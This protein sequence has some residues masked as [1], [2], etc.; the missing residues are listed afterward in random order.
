MI[1]ADNR[2]HANIQYIR[3]NNTSKDERNSL[4]T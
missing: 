3:I 2:W 1:Y 4:S